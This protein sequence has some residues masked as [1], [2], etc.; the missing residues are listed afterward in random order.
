MT[1][2]KAW[3]EAI[4][5]ARR[6]L[7]AH[8]DTI[9]E[10]NRHA[11]QTLRLNAVVVSLVVAGL[12]R[13]SPPV[14][15]ILVVALGGGFVV[16]SSYY[17]FRALHTEPVS[18]GIPPSIYEDLKNQNVNAEDYYHHIGGTIYPQAI[19]DA[20]SQSDRYS[21]ELDR[22]YRFAAIGILVLV[23][24][25]VLMW[26]NSSTLPEILSSSSAWVYT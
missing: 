14:T 23:F 25:G 6:T 24:G 2:E 19:R 13:T 3:E 20:R 17:A 21:D 5:D 10:L 4:T 8:L 12:Y 11:S 22:V 7:Q 15:V 9:D 16:L 1:E 18:G 26:F